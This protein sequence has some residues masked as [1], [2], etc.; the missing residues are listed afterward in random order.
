MEQ[1][2]LRNASSEDID[3]IFLVRVESM[4]SDFEKTSRWNDEE[5]YRKA[6]DEIGQAQIIMMEGLPVG[7]IKVLTREHELHLHQMQI[8]PCCQGR[9]IGSALVRMVLQR[10]DSLN[11]P[12]TLFVLKGARARNLCE[13]MGFSLVEENLYNFRMCR[14]PDGGLST[15]A[16]R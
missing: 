6:A 7:V 4:K 5:Q 15:S 13:R 9:G 14:Y 16:N 1:F 10:A 12:V 2:S 8:L 11:F 3:F